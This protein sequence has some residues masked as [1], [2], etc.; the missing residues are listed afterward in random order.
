MSAELFGRKRLF[1]ARRHERLH[2]AAAELD[3]QTGGRVGRN[4]RAAAFAAFDERFVGAHVQLAFRFQVVVAAGTFVIKNGFN[5]LIVGQG[6]FSIEGD[7]RDGLRIGR[8]DDGR[9]KQRDQ[10]KPISGTHSGI[11][12]I[13]V[14]KL[15]TPVSL[16]RLWAYLN[17]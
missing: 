17:E 6:V 2:G 15:P 10:A 14:R 3:E 7:D 11:S 5:V 13:S 12:L 8:D 1:V 9:Q 4:D 16:Q